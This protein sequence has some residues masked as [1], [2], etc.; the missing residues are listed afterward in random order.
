MPSII[1]DYIVNIVFIAV[2]FVSYTA[3][4]HVL[5]RR[6]ILVSVILLN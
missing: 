6:A 5:Q 1:L 2:L 4:S 3:S